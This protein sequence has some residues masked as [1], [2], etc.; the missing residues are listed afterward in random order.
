MTESTYRCSTH[1]EAR[2][3]D[4]GKSSHIRNPSTPLRR[5]PQGGQQQDWLVHYQNRPWWLVHKTLKSPG[6]P[7]PRA[8]SAYKTGGL[9]PLSRRSS[10]RLHRPRHRFVGRP[11]GTRSDTECKARGP[12]RI[13]ECSGRRSS[14]GRSPRRTWESSAA[15]TPPVSRY[16]GP[17]PHR[18]LPH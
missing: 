5:V 14:V 16:R 10:A 7:A 17:S 2:S 4:L 13:S 18:S 3:S 8:S 12:I 11:A 6:N 9:R 15:S 1:C